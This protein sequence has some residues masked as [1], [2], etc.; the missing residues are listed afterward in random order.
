MQPAKRFPVQ[1]ATDILEN[2]LYIPF[3]VGNFNLLRSYVG[4][5]YTEIFFYSGLY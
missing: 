1:S 3:L 5:I 4:P 2:T